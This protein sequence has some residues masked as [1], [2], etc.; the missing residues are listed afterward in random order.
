MKSERTMDGPSV[1]G[2]APPKSTITPENSPLKG[3]P[4][5][6]W[7]GEEA[8]AKQSEPAKKPPAASEAEGKKKDADS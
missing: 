1:A 4:G 7:G 6:L 5:R 2:T 8:P 3:A